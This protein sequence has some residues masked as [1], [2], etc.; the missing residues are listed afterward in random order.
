MGKKVNHSFFFGSMWRVEPPVARVTDE[1][2]AR[3]EREEAAEWAKAAATAER[4][5]WVE[6]ADG[7]R[8][9]L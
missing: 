8:W 9:R 1:V 6:E 2:M 5:W 3:E 7:R 4:V